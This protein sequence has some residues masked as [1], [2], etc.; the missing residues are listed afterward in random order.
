MNIKYLSLTLLLC[1]T[2]SY[3]VARGSKAHLKTPSPS[4]QLWDLTLEGDKKA[5]KTGH[6]KQYIVHIKNLLKE[7]AKPAA[8]YPIMH[9]GD[10]RSSLGNALDKND[11]E[12]LAILLNHLKEKKGIKHTKDIE[13]IND[14]AAIDGQTLLAF[15]CSQQNKEAVAVL[16]HH[17]A[18]PNAPSKSGKTPLEAALTQAP[19]DT[20]TETLRILL[21]AGADPTIN[22]AANDDKLEELWGDLKQQADSHQLIDSK[23]VQKSPVFRTIKMLFQALFIY[24]EAQ[25]HATVEAAKNHAKVVEDHLVNLQAI[26]EFDPSFDPINQPFPYGKKA[27]LDVYEKTPVELAAENNHTE[28]LQ[29]MLTAKDTQGNLLVSISTARKALTAANK[30]KSSQTQKALNNFISHKGKETP[31][32]SLVFKN[33]VKEHQQRAAYQMRG[34]ATSQQI[35]PGI[36]SRLENDIAKIVQQKHPSLPQLSAQ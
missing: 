35:L 27:D 21:A 5:T 28:C 15:A 26:K 36:V 30:G 24:E 23:A 8:P 17:G 22:I 2:S 29:A 31:P 20:T 13:L 32:S 19:S 33:I 1:T 16:V 25:Q 7:G 3:H 6:S 4:E 18:D 10:T 11:L 12:V 34:G 14:N 9:S